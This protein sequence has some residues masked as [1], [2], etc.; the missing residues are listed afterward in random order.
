M[1]VWSGCKYSH[2]YLENITVCILLTPIKNSED[3]DEMPHINKN[4][5]GKGL[6]CL[7]RQKTSSMKER[8]YHSEI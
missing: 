1:W 4:F 8:E 6:H 3:P 7:F 5:T 2:K